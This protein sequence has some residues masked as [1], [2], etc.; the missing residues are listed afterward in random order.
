MDKRI[1]TLLLYV[2]I[3]VALLYTKR[4]ETFDNGND[5]I[6]FT[7]FADTKYKAT[8]E[9]IKNEAEYINLF[10][11]VYTYDE[12]T[13]DL[14]RHKKFIEENSRGY[15]Y[16]IWKPKV[17]L[18]TLNKIPDGSYLV[19]ADAGCTI[20]KDSEIG[21]RE[22]LKEIDEKG[23]VA[24]KWRKNEPECMWSK[25]DTIKKVGVDHDDKLALIATYIYFKKNENSMRFMNEWLD[26]CE[27]DAY[28]N[29]DDS[30]SLEPNCG[31]FIEHRHDQSIFSILCHKYG[32]KM[33]GKDDETTPIIGTRL[34]F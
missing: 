32:I 15:G 25:M 20:K 16:W 5:E 28:H 7:S 4:T 30:P 2:L 24:F 11:K 21:I 27:S 13:I 19:Y 31:S 8:L 14:S 23:L 18:D 9:R 12:N 34:K 17:I 10:K 29:I 33:I 3:L 26:I 1:L 6:Y 22:I